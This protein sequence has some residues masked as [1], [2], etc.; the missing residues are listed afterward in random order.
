MPSAAP[1]TPRDVFTAFQDALDARDFA[2]A[3]AFYAEDVHVTQ[4][5]AR[6]EPATLRGRAALAEHFA[7]AGDLPLTLTAVHRVIH[8]T[9]DPEVIV[10]EYD[11]DAHNHA[12]GKR[13]RFANVVVAR[14]RDARIT[15]SRDYH[16]PTALL[17][18]LGG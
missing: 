3:V 4:P 1:G 17:E 11:Y 18:L 5:F 7:R 12:T 13:I 10:V 6:P 2:A 15:E 9:A 8:D 16:D 14:I